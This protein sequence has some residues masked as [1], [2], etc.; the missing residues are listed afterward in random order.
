MLNHNK[1]KK[2]LYDIKATGKI[3]EKQ[4]LWKKEDTNTQVHQK[5]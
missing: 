4:K 2:K 1:N 3:Y 5:N